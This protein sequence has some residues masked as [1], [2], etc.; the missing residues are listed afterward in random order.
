VVVGDVMTDV[1]ARFDRPLVPAGDTP[2]SITL[3]PG[4][5]GA[6]TAAWLGHLGVPTVFA[7][8][9]GDDSL[10]RDAARAL[11]RAGVTPRLAIVAAAASGACVVLVDASGER[12][13]LPDGG[14]NARLAPEHLPRDA[15]VA[16]GHLHLSGY[17]LLRPATRPAALAALAAARE[18]GMA[19]S[20]DAAS[21]APLA[22]V[23][24][25]PFRHL[26]RGVDTALVTLDEAEVLCGS[27]DPDAIAAALLPGWR[28][29]VLKL[30]PDGAEWRGPGGALARVP[31]A[32][33]S[34]PAVDT[35]GAGDAFAAGWLAARREGRDPETALGRACA[36]AATAVTRRGARP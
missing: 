2:A 13:M 20:I 30:G 36:L 1:L 17:T 35:T 5:S 3:R 29:V 31:A 27:R 21:A 34:E 9:V 25:E 6:N 15:F 33:P 19:T 24:G 11:R 8:C 22:D 4:G 12:T 18:A 14:A 23:G 26:A 10:G 7:G 28:E 32:L 16:G